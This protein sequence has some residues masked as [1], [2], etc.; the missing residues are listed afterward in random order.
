LT[1]IFVQIH[2]DSAA[3]LR[4][5]APKRMP[6]ERKR[7]QTSARN[8]SPN[9]IQTCQGT[10][11]VSTVI[12]LIRFSASCCSIAAS[13]PVRSIGVHADDPR[14]NKVSRGPDFRDAVLRCTKKMSPGCRVQVLRQIPC[15]N[16]F[17]TLSTLTS[18]QF[19]DITPEEQYLRMF[20]N[21][22]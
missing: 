4:R 13:L 8:E 18:A 17:F 12:D 14:M 22:P 2:I 7:D 11:Y 5:I 1:K 19:I 9:K 16:I 6:N 10:E 3:A 21:S 15:W 20:E